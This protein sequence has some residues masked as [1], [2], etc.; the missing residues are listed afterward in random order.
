MA[1]ACEDIAVGWGEEPLVFSLSDNG[2]RYRL[3][4]ALLCLLKYEL[5]AVHTVLGNVHRE[6]FTDVLR[7]VAAVPGLPVFLQCKRARGV[8]PQLDWIPTR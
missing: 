1:Q 3:G 8:F 2:V 7:I 5:L 6:L 4:I